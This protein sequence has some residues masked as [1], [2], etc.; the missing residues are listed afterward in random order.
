MK[1]T[2][3]V[4]ISLLMAVTM[5]LTA[6]APAAPA[7]VPTAQVVV[8]TQIVEKPVEATVVVQSTVIVQATAVPDEM[9]Q[10]K[11]FLKGKKIC[12]ILP[13][14]VN[15]GGWNEVA[16]RGL[17]NLR[18]NFGMEILYRE[19]TKPEDAAGVMRS[20]ADAGCSIIQ[21][22]GSEFTDAVNSVAQE[23]PKIQFMQLSRCAGQEPNVIGLCYSTGEGGYFIGL[24]AGQITKTGKVAYVVGTKYPNMDWNPTMSQQAV[25]DL[26]A[27]GV[28]T[29]DVT[30]EEKEVGSWDDAA[31]AKELTT[32][33]IAEG[34]DVIIMIADAA[35]AG[36]IQAVKEA[37]D[38]GK[39]VMAISWSA[40]KN[41]MGHDFVIGG[42]AER[43]DFEMQYAAVQYALAGQPIGKGF[44]LGLKEG[45][46]LLSPMYG[47]VSP[48]VEK[49]VVDAYQKYLA[50]P[51]AFPNLVVR[52]DL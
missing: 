16:Y 43:S 1:K 29:Q 20:Y 40:D 5:I 3:V 44:P 12:A 51:K 9:A 50:D 27:A 13:G 33:L 41:Y 46:V 48:E 26:K 49:Y 6:C 32:A 24:L 47:L 28:I 18:D 34:Y 45:A 15:D 2:S 17:I 22:H 21:G 31:K 25:K 8:Q 36:S 39:K 37:R 10:A 14:T 30:V 11:A 4:M 38:A 19:T 7:E 42:W 23:Y 52:T 35:D